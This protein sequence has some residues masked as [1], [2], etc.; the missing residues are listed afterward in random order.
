MVLDLGAVKAAGLHLLA[1]HSEYSEV[2]SP[3]HAAIES[4]T[5]LA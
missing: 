2:S 4:N 5:Q 1:M 3:E